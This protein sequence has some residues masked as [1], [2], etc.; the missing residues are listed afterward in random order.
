VRARSLLLAASLLLATAI[1]AALADHREGPCDFHQEADESTRH[2]S[3]RQIRCA[4][5]EFGPVRG[6]A[7]RAIC[8]ADRESGLQPA[9][10]SLTGQY[11]GLY[12]HAAEYWD[13]RYDTYTR[14][15]WELPASALRGRT[16]AIVTIRMVFEAGTWPAA[17][18]PRGDC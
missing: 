7:E 2:F 16:N 1:P 11:L 4:V 15:G 12:Q 10:E 18:W 14:A 5:A 13:W 3:I 8:I 17:G 6:G 9:A